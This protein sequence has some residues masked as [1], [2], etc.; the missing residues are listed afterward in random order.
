MHLGQSQG[1]EW[2]EMVERE[3]AMAEATAVWRSEE[4]PGGGEEV[5]GEE[6]RGVDAVVGGGAGRAGGWERER[7]RGVGRARWDTGGAFRAGEGWEAGSV[8]SEGGRMVKQIEQRRVE[9][10][11]ECVQAVHV[12]EGEEEDIR[13]KRGGLGF[14]VEGFHCWA[15]EG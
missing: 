4:G 7:E 1:S 9:G 5:G 13:N 8:V 15:Q 3:A 11:L 6:E 14:G 2:E 12:H 10:G